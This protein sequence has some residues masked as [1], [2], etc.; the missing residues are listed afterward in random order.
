VGV[1]RLEWTVTE[2]WFSGLV[3]VALAGAAST[4][5]VLLLGAMQL[6]RAR[7]SL[8]RMRRR[9]SRPA[10]LPRTD[11]G[12]RLA[13]DIDGVIELVRTDR[14]RA[15]A[16]PEIEALT[17]AETLLDRAVSRYRTSTAPEPASSSASRRSNAPALGEPAPATN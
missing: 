9:R 3:V 15:S 1:P 16:R 7:L 17:L 4:F 5:V 8:P 2:G 14:L 11:A 13:F 10:P 12:D 6:G